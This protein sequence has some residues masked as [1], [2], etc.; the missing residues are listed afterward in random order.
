M[1]PQANAPSSWDESWKALQS[2]V[3]ITENVPVLAIAA[4][5]VIGGLLALYLRFLYRHCNS[6]FSGAD[7]VAR[8]FPLLTMVTIGVIA[9]VK[10]SL[11]LSLGLVGALSIVR[12]RAA[13]KEPE[14]LVYLF[15]CIGVGLAL[16]AEQPLLAVAGTTAG[17][18]LL[19]VARRRRC[20]HCGKPLTDQ[21]GTLVDADNNSE[22][23]DNPDGHH[24]LKQ[25]NHHS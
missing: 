3:S 13:I 17:L 10:S 8:I 19:L 1:D 15:L 2:S 20:E 24:Q 14:E 12:F 22:C 16:G 21:D 23:A 7:S 9:V 11:A 18:L 5:M 6:S 4:Y 25:S